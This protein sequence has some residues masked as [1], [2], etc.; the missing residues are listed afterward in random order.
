MDGITVAS[1]TDTMEDVNSAAGIESTEEQ[2]PQTEKP[3]KQ[4]AKAEI[5]PPKPSKS[6]AQ[7]RFDALTRE[8]H[9]LKAKLEAKEAPAAQV[10]ADAAPVQ[11]LPNKPTFAEF[12]AQGKTY[13]DYIE[14]LTDWK[15]EQREAA[16]AQEEAQ[17][18]EN[19]RIQATIAEWNDHANAARR[20]YDD[21][22]ETLSDQVPIYQG[23]LNA[24]V[25]LENGPEVAYWLGKNRDQAQEL[26]KLTETRA[27][28]RIGQISAELGNGDVIS[29]KPDAEIAEEEAEEEEPR[30]KRR[31]IS[32]APAPI[33]PV[34]GSSTKSSVPLDEVDYATY[35]KIRDQQIKQKYRR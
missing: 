27:I 30:P 8:I 31:A 22:D 20:K 17:R 1:T 12:Q 11:E 6:S 33:R 24:L 2:K 18:A 25:E 32:A 21:F 5:V 34:G 14:A 28:A 9:E 10:E 19:E 7:R 35:R 16:K 13:D 4:E 23:V 3:E 26:M 15:L 29:E